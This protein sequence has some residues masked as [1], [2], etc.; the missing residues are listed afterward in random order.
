MQTQGHLTDMRFCCAANVVTP[1]VAR[2]PDVTRDS[3]N[4]LLG[5][6]FLSDPVGRSP[7]RRK[8]PDQANTT[9]LLLHGRH[10]SRDPATGPHNG[11]DKHTDTGPE[12][13]REYEACSLKTLFESSA[14]FLAYACCPST[15]IPGVES[16]A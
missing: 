13:C 3:S 12:N 2:E 7:R 10:V 14:D 8:P 16:H 6:R 4:R 5:R 11:T 15:I 1:G 9:P